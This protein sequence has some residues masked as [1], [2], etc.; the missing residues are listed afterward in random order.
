M[1]THTH[2]HTHFFTP[3]K[4]YKTTFYHHSA[5]VKVSNVA[6]HLWRL[7]YSGVM[8]HEAFIRLRAQAV[9]ATQQ[10]HAL[11]IHVERALIITDMM[12]QPGR[13]IYRH[14]RAPAAVVVRPDQFDLWLAYARAMERIG[15]T[16]MIFLPHQQHLADRFLDCLVGAQNLVEQQWRAE[17]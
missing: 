1:H 7:D 5:R 9:Q 4:Q 16:R 8:G 10:A 6:R 2:T 12:P 17:K 13:D 15:I 3:A 14:N 11:Q